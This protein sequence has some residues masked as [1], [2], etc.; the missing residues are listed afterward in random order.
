MSHSL[1][2]FMSKGVL[3][4]GKQIVIREK[5]K[6][7]NTHTSTCTDVLVLDGLQFIQFL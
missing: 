2:C 3:S 7:S 1:N 4:A 6:I 5:S